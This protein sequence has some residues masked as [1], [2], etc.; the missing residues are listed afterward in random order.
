[1]TAVYYRDLLAAI[2]EGLDIPHPATAGDTDRYRQVLEDRAMYVRVAIRCVLLQADTPQDIAE[3]TA[4]L[5]ERLAA[6]PT[7]SYRPWVPR[8]GD[9]GT[10]R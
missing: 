3:N 10:D 7:N 6:V 1:V 9:E 4:D 5:R 8:T 2:L